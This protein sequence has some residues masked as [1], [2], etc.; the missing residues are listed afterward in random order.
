MSILES[1]GWTE[2]T[3]GDLNARSE[4]AQKVRD[5]FRPAFGIE[6][7]ITDGENVSEYVR[8]VEH[9]RYYLDENNN[10][11]NIDDEFTEITGYTE[12]DIRERK[13]KQ[14]DLIPEPEREEYTMTVNAQLAK[15]NTVFLE[16]RI[17]CR[18]GNIIRVL[19]LGRYYYDSAYMNWRSEI[20]ITIA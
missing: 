15:K 14:T 17:V 11:T 10:I 4:N 18:N 20:N 9:S 2:I 8:N 5:A 1:P 19:C 3:E 16:H 12:E 13:L 6:N 7:A